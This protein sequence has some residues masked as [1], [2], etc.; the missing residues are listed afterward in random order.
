M[1]FSCF[2]NTPSSCYLFQAW[3][4]SEESG[5]DLF[6][7]TYTLS[8]SSAKIF[9]QFVGQPKFFCPLNLVQKSFDTSK[10]TLAEIIG[11]YILWHYW[12]PQY[13]YYKKILISALQIFH[14]KILWG[15]RYNLCN[16]QILH[17]NPLQSFCRLYIP[18]IDSYLFCKYILHSAF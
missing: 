4:N 3:R 8:N 2:F 17:Y 12:E 9:F 11:L 18:F 7:H 10:L 1:E 13:Y 5:W 14:C 15:R 6:E 16:I